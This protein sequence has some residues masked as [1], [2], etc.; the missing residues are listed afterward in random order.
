MCH[1][2]IERRRRTQGATLQN[3][4]DVVHKVRRYSSGGACPRHHRNR[5]RNVADKLRRHNDRDVARKV[6]GYRIARSIGLHA[7]WPETPNRFPWLA[8]YPTVLFYEGETE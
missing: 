6:R 4:G 8:G 7:D 5:Y 3:G 2:G 1:M